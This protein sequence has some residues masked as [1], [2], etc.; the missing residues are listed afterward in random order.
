MQAR[1]LA[2]LRDHN[3][4]Y[5]SQTKLLHH[6]SRSSSSS[7][8]VAPLAVDVGDSRRGLAAVAARVVVVV[9]P[10]SAA[11]AHHHR[12]VAAGAG[13]RSGASR[14]SR[15]VHLGGAGTHGDHLGEIGVLDHLTYDVAARGLNVDAV[16]LDESVTC[17]ASSR[18]TDEI[19][20]SI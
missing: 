15:G 1:V 14:C 5:R 8:Y 20:D 3:G 16:H 18:G 9:V 10:R 19:V 4:I 11:A 12:C 2:K 7:A 17:G 13:V 6:N